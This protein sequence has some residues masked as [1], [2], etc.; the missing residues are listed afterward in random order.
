MHTFGTRRIGPDL[1]RVGAK[2]P[3]AWLSLA[4]AFGLGGRDAAGRQLERWMG[5]INSNRD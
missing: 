1:H 5:S 2:Y 3:D 4:I